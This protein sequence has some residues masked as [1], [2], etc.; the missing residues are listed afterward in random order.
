MKLTAEILAFHSIKNSYNPTLL[1]CGF[2]KLVH[3]TKGSAS[4][5]IE[6]I[7]NNLPF[8]KEKYGDS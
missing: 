6:Q 4:Y 7:F 2:D 8:T 3:L 5:Q 1:G